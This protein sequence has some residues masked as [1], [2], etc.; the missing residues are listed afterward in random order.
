MDD[1]EISHFT[2]PFSLSECMTSGSFELDSCVSS[3]NQP[4][5]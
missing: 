2:L 5:N 3:K 1:Y 4:Y